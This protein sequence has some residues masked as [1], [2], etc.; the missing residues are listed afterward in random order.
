MNERLL[1]LGYQKDALE[2]Q[3][4]DVNVE[5]QRE[6][7]NNYIYFICTKI[8]KDNPYLNVK[9][10]TNLQIMDDC[11]LINFNN[12]YCK[13]D[14]MYIIIND[15]FMNY[16]YTHDKG[17]IYLNRYD[18]TSHL[19]CNNFYLNNPDIFN[20]IIH[21][22]LFRDKIKQYIKEYNNPGRIINY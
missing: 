18:P 5:I 12:I 17:V 9:L 3:L 14:G 4:V 11:V 7:L 15:N 20:I 16:N 6:M 8:N 19:I 13:I 2:K 22:T 21:I 1:H 10:I